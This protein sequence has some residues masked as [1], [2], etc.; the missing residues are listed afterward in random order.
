MRAFARLLAAAV[1]LALAYAAPVAAQGAPT[2]DLFDLS[3]D[4]L[5]RVDVLSVSRYAQPLS[6]SPASVT[7]LDAQEIQRQGYRTLAEALSTVGG[8]D[9]RQDRAYSYLGVRGLS[10]PG[11]YNARVLLLTDG[12]R[13]NEAVYDQASLGHESPIEMDWIKRLEFAAG[14][15]SAVYGAN[16]L[17]GTVNAVMLEGG[18]V[19]GVRTT[20]D[21]GSGQSTRVGLVAG[22][23]A[24]ATQEWFLGLA[25]YASRGADVYQSEWDTGAQDGWARDLDGERYQKVYAKLRLGSWRLTGNLSSRDKQ[26]PNAPYG[27]VFGQAGT[28]VQ[29]QHALL[30]L[31]FDGEL[32]AGWS[33]QFR[34]FTAGYHYVGD[35]LYAD[36][37]LNRDT[38]SARWAGADYRWLIKTVPDHTWV[39]GMET[40]RNQKIQQFNG[41]VLTGT[42]HLNSDQPSRTVGLYVQD[43]WHFAQR[44]RLYLGLRHD[45]HSDFSAIVSPRL[46]LIHQSDERTT[47]KAMLGSAYRVP[48]AYERFYQ[49]GDELQ[50]AN[51]SLRPEQMHSVELSVDQQQPE[52]LRWGGRVYRHVV[53]DL[54]DQVQDP[55][56]GLNVFIN[57]S[58][59][60]TRGIEL[61]AGKHWS[62]GYRLRA[63][64]SRQGAAMTDGSPLVNSPAWLGKLVFSAPVAPGWTLAGQW[65]TQSEVRS[66]S[67]QVAGHGVVNLSLTAALGPRAG[68][69]TLSV[70]NLA[71]QSYSDPVSSA[72]TADAQARD[73]RQFRLR[74]TWSL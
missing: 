62:R 67:S 19:N 37:D 12:A 9:V 56:D 31:A 24:D 20:V 15:A 1:A 32:S 47:F 25:A 63:S 66:L 11:D 61:H 21:L 40:Q 65:L 23:R 72:F 5:L 48:N 28:Q 13:R 43:E 68:D 53:R 50:K 14:P 74:W 7:V 3:L 54:I 26:L 6:E 34:M 29:D 73:G 45:K 57:R 22:Q 59:V 17:F 70:Y 10:R 39:L 4:D 49:D 27:T 18:D 71:N 51:P 55:L 64:V 69:L 46:A 58:S 2:T 52:G 16:A 42:V 60:Q 30:E 33:Q 8:L 36:D 38:V 44:W 35:Y 41:D